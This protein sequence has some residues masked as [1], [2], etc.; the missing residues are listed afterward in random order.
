[1]IIRI[2]DGRP[3]GDSGSTTWWALARASAMKGNAPHGINTLL[4][5]PKVTHIDVFAGEATEVW[6]WCERFDG[7]VHDGRKQLK[8]QPLE[9]T[10]SD[11]GP[12]SIEMLRA[13]RG[14]GDRRR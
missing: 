11:A 7:W 13:L 4:L 3:P 12:V 8:S 2:S 9:S 1:V 5:D 14:T 6:Q 10:Q